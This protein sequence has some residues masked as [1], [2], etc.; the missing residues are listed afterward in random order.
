MNDAQFN[1]MMNELKAQTVAINTLGSG[2]ATLIQMQVQAA[3]EQKKWLDSMF[4]QQQKTD[5]E[6]MLDHWRR[7]G[8][9]LIGEGDIEDARSRSD[10]K[11][12]PTAEGSGVAQRSAP[13]DGDVSGGGQG[14]DTSGDTR[15]DARIYG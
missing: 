14:F 11:V 15:R 6:S 10:F 8:G 5:R 13:Q 2:V 1:T 9:P 7:A 3:E 12:I 4:G